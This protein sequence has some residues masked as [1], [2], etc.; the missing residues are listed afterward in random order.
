VSVLLL[1]VPSVAAAN[2]LPRPP[3]N[4]DSAS[5]RNDFR[6]VK[7]KR[8]ING[9]ENEGIE[10]L[11][12][13]FGSTLPTQAKEAHR[14]SATFTNPLDSCVS[15]SSKLSGSI[16]L[17]L[18]GDCAFTTKAEVAQ[19]GGAVGLVVINDDEDLV[20]MACGNETSFDISIP[21]IIISKSSGEELKKFMDKGAKV[22]LLLY[23]PNWPILDY[24]VIFLWLMAVGTVVS[25]SLWPE[26]TRSER[27]N[28]Y[29][30]EVPHYQTELYSLADEEEK[31]TFHVTA[32]SAVIFVITSS[33]FL[34]LLYFFMSSWF[35]WLL[36][37]LFCIG[38]I[39]G[40]HSCIVSLALSKCRGCGQKTVN[41]PVIGEISIFSLLVL[42]A[43]TIFTI[44]WA[45]NHKASYS[46]VGQD[47]LGICMMITVL[48]LAQLPNIKVS[49]VLLCCAFIYDVF[50][51]F[52]SP[53][54]FHDSVMIAV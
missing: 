39:E 29:Y 1:F 47:V 52:L 32:K 6:S 2:D 27:S 11:S 15:S 17:A 13:D 26:I 31:E 51:V 33:S 16:A 54:I 19:A 37:V 28:E 43:C 23:S 40:M 21:V 24:S 48:Q 8:W 45:S 18:R 42:I 49:T 7:V 41:L 4:G 3:T 14:Y 22:E 9:V 30:N 12:A 46:W 35:I 10:G 25:A 53:L 38:G 44:I 34:L 5:C 36:I 50:W 20:Q